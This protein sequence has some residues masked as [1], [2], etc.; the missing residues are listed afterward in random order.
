MGKWK[1]VLNNVI[2][3]RDFFEVSSIKELF[4][5]IVE[6]AKRMSINFFFKEKFLST[7]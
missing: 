2:S 1:F 6:S 7:H 5:G 4:A 3:A